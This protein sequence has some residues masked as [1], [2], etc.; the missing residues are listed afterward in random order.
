MPQYD[1]EYDD[2]RMSNYRAPAEMP[3]SGMGVASLFIAILVGIGLF[4]L[5]A[6]ATAM[7]MGKN[8]PPNNNDPMMVLVGLGIIGG[9]GLALVGLVLGIIGALQSNRKSLCGILGAS[10]NGLI[11]LGVGGLM[12][13]GLA[14]GG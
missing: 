2:I 12:C 10:F 6:I 1:D 4:A 7:A 14:V 8:G 13:L 9:C 3:Q 11:L 5:I